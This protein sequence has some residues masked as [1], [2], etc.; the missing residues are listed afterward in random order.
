M[1]TLTYKDYLGR[2]EYDPDADLFH[3]EVLNIADVVTFQGRSIDELKTALAESL[4]DY[5]ELCAEIGKQ[6]QKPFSG[7]FNVRIPPEIHQRAA[8][9]AARDGISLNKWVM[10]TLEKA[11]QRP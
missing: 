6:P 5:F 8:A 7:N 2:F 4:E 9:S 1:N 11:V 10:K 3:G